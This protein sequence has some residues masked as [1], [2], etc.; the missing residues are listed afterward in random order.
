MP[1]VEPLPLAQLTTLRTGGVPARMIDAH[2]REELV[3]ALLEVWGEGEPWLVLG[4]GSNLFVGDDP[5]EGTVV[6]I[7]TQGI[8]R[9][10]SSRTGFT[11]LRVE[12][13]H[14]W[15]ALVAYAVEHG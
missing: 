2:T 9:M 12:A 13:G 11:R 7:L 10:P 14:D 15:D 3:A 5:F 8:E 4:G 1:H 6:R